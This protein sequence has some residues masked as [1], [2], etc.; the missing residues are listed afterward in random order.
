MLGTHRPSCK[1]R[2][3]VHLPVALPVVL[4]PGGLYDDPPVTAQWFWVETGVAPML[5][6]RNVDVLVHDRPTDA[7][8]WSEEA[9]ALAATIAAAGH[10]QVA[11]VAGSNGCSVAL[12]LMLDR[13]DLVARTLLCW[14]ATAGHPVIDGLAHTIISDVH[15]AHVAEQLLKGA[16]IRGVSVDE[17]AAISGEVVVYPSMP[18]S[19]AHQRSTVTELLSTIPGV[20][21]VGGS[22]EPFD[23]AFADF[24]EGFVDLVEAFSKIH[25]D[26]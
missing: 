3:V 8:S 10:S 11:L 25:H 19:Q 7:R 1:A 22:P 17:L 2:S 4:V 24:V 26:D 5:G 18:E 15:N 12:R 14:P 16:P 23:D 9:E 20:M 21:L 13:P 6:R